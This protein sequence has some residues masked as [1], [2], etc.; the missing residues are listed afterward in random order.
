VYHREMQ[1]LTAFILAGGKS[2]RMGADKAFLEWQGQTLLERA[3][4][5]AHTVTQQVALV[6]SAEKLASYGRVVEDVY[7]ERGPLGGIHA[8]L[9]ATTTDLN[10]VIGVDMP[11]LRSELLHFLV[12]QARAHGTALVTVPRSGEGWQP[13]CAVYRQGFR[14]LAESALKR[15]ENKI[16]SLFAG[17]Q[18][19][20]VEQSDLEQKG[21]AAGVF[22]NLNTP[23]ELEQARQG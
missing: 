5:L 2:T 12:E 13:L 6:G 21:F 8:A 19:C 17:T 16:D 23:G 14:T 9:R 7:R 10:L 20:I 15:G 22:R 3:L 4:E 11:F 1:D 18:T